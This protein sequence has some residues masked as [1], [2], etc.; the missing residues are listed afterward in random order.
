[1]KS[2]RRLIVVSDGC[3]GCD[4]GSVFERNSVAYLTTGTEL[5]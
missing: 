5:A 1:M 2:L 3:P 4:L